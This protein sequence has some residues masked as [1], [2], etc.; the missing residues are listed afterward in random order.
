MHSG[1][2]ASGLDSFLA[3]QKSIGRIDSEG[4]FTIA[5]HAA[6]GKLGSFQLP[7]ATAWI[8]KV[9]QAAVA[10]GA[11][12]LQVQQLAQAT[13]FTFHPSERMAAAD[14]QQALVSVERPSVRFLDHLA[15]GLRAVGFG[16]RRAF[17]LAYEEGRH[18]TLFG[19]YGEELIGGQE[20]LD[21]SVPPTVR[22]GVAFPEDD[23]GRIMGMRSG[24]RSSDEYLEL[25]RNAC[26]CPIPVTVDGRR[27]DRLGLA[28]EKWQ[29][30]KQLTLLID[31]ASSPGTALPEFDLPAGLPQQSGWRPTDRFTDERPFQLGAQSR[32]K[33]VQVLWRVSYSYKVVS[34]RGKHK[35]FEFRSIPRPSE[36]CWLKDGVIVDRRKLLE[37]HLATS[38]QLF[39]SA[40]DLEADLSGLTLREDPELE[41]R[42]QKARQATVSGLRRLRGALESYQPLPFATHAALWGG[43]GLF[44][45]ATLPTA[46]KALLGAG[47]TL[48]LLM[49]AQDKRAIVLDSASSLKG[50]L[51]ELQ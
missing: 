13:Y 25:V 42:V 7:R 14:L 8:L 38:M 26:A 2:P 44:M 4:S 18:Q 28:H 11:A 3:Q 43:F 31:W 12:S 47:A 46:G 45:V 16:D 10:S 5:G 39:L 30:W 32:A 17:T 22:L 29:D 41:A 6:I 50:L 15:T 21:E 27:I 48:A 20:N 9:V 34:H 51:A 36:V 19:W 35:S 23:P 24:Q 1:W 49:S 33:P 40:E 37:R